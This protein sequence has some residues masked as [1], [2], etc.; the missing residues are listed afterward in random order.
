MA[1]T[2]TFVPPSWLDDQSA[3][4]IHA[5]MMGNLP[6]DIDDTEG[7][8][9]WD[10]TK[11][12]ALEKA[13]LLE[14]ETM[15]TLKL[16]HYMFAYGIYLDYHAESYGLRRRGSVAASGEVSVTGSPGTVIPQGFLF[17]VPARGSSP[18]I[19]FSAN[20]TVTLDYNGEATVQV[21]CTQTGLIGN[22][23]ADTI[24]I[25]VSPIE[26]I[27]GI[28]NAEMLTGGA[29]N[30]ADNVLRERIREYLK[31]INVSFAGCDA[32]YKRWSME[33]DSVGSVTVIPEWDGAGTVK[34]VV[35]DR[36]FAPANAAILN[37]VYDHIVSP[38][39]RDNRL[40]PIGATVTVAAPTTKQIAIS[41]SISVEPGADLEEIRESIR[42]AVTAYIHSGTDII[43]YAKIGS[44]ILGTDGV[45]DYSD[46]E[47]NGDTE[48]VAV[49]PDEYPALSSLS[50][51]EEEE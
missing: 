35:L 6:D 40:A 30:E 33:L 26:G 27:S 4:T 19:A 17:A 9:P 2:F 10:F 46:L 11:P 47:L 16:M 3:E 5:R 14:Y 28:T 29:E 39:N 7:G 36:N 45:T 43:R 24:V 21:T 42:S 38:D 20:D 37:E 23:A 48:N 15:E 34:V 32:D 13:E 51:E 18:A 44:I 31:T 49:A 12:T 22:V 41:F 50:V 25:M 8:F 1:D